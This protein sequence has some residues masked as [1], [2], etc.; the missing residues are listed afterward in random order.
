[1]TTAIQIDNLRKVYGP[2]VALDGASHRFE[3]GQVHALVGKNGSG[4]STMVKILNGAVQPTEGT[5]EL[6]DAPVAFADPAE[7]MAA[8]VVT[9][10][11]ELSLVP[12]LSVLENVLLGRMPSRRLLGV[13]RIDWAEARGI[14]FSVI[15]SL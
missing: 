5:I 9:V 14:G 13:D 1:M 8:G 4:K 12:E 6:F 10:Y 2:T 15:A 11:Q 7:A 3:A